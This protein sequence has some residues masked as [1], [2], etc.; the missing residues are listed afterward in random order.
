MFEFSAQGSQRITNVSQNSESEAS[1]ASVSLAYYFW[2]SGAIEFTYMTGYNYSRSTNG[3]TVLEQS[4]NFRYGGVDLIYNIGDR[5]SVFSPYIK[6]GIAEITK[7]LDFRENGSLVQTP[8][9][10]GKNITYGAG[11]R[12]RIT[13]SFSFRVSYDVWT[14]PIDQELQTTDSSFKV[15]FSWML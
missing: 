10:K 8:E 12:L 4:L 15:G 6:A 7:T 11:F 5:E 3:T 14:G 9:E 13:Q 1:S 2:Q